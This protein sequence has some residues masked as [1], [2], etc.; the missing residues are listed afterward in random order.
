VDRRVLP[1]VGDRV[2]V[3]FDLEALAGRQAA[4]AQLLEERQKPLVPGEA[5]GGVRFLQVGRG[6]L[7]RGPETERR[8]QLR[9]IA[10]LS[11]SRSCR[12]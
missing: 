12:W 4:V 7:E 2:R 6:S 3:A 8:F 5:G 11:F 9:V 10:S 1:D